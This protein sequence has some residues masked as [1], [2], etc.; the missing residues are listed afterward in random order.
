[1]LRITAVFAIMLSFIGKFGA[2][3][4]S[5][6]SPVM[7]GISLILFSM[8]AIVGV[9]TIKNENI[10][11]N[12][13]NIIVM[14][15]ILFVGLSG[16]FMSAPIGIQITTNV[17]LSGLSLAALVGVILNLVLNKIFK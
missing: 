3:V 7:G 4:K 13:K 8:I 2:I 10:K 15:A 11:F 1:M 6:P 9:K 5:I 14:G 16:V 17:S 12:V